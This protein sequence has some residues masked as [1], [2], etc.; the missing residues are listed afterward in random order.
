LGARIDILFIEIS[1]LLFS[2]VFL[3]DGKKL[4]T[5]EEASAKLDS[6]KFLLRLAWEI[7]IMETKRY[8]RLSE[9]L[10]LVGRQLGG[11]LKKVRSE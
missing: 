8:A 3:E 7:E 6:A 2:T 10:D 5:L 11:W 9:H 1:E 4:L